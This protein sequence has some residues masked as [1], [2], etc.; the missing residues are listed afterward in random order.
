MEHFSLS[1]IPIAIPEL[2]EAF[3][4]PAPVDRKDGVAVG[5]L[6]ADGDKKEMIIKL[7]HEI[8][9]QKHGRFDSL[10]IAHKNTLIFESYYSRGR[11]NLPHPQASATK[12]YLNMTIGRAVQL[13]Y[14]TM[15]DLHK[16]LVSFLKHLDPTKFVDG[17]EK[18]TLHQAMTMHS[19]IR[20]SN[21]K[22]KELNENP[23]Q[24]K[25]QRQVQAYLEHSEPITIESE[26]YLYQRTDPQLVMQVLDAVVP[27]TA[28]DFIRDDFFAKIEITN[29]G[30]LDSVSGLPEGPHSSRLTSRDM[31]KL[32]ILAMN[33]G[34]WE[35]E[36]IIPE[37]FVTKSIN[38]IVQ[39]GVEDIFF[40]GESV[41]N[42][43]YGYY[44]WQADMAVG[45]QSYFSTSAQGG[46]GQY[47]ILI[48]ELDLVVVA[49]AHDRDA[50]TMQ[51]TAERI[52]PAFTHK[53]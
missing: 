8:A 37:A 44:W 34:M 11:V 1:D 12:S 38:R 52:V 21:D 16:P 36:Q 10:L 22:L 18:I 2:K 29:Y 33:T 14:L 25:G 23:E 31:I 50:S 5:A 26:S 27:G 7:A 40:V 28:K 13:G 43:G 17:V 20:I 39:K 32:G 45:K 19:G 15:D 53:Q 42:P 4:D 6:G 24:I 41:S 30:W 35:G 9:E 51:M 48:D 46:G 47:I 3:I 49:T